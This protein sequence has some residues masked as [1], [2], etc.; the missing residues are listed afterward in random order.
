MQIS[1]DRL[2]L[3][4]PDHAP[5]DFEVTATS[6]SMARRYVGQGIAVSVAPGPCSD[7]MSDAVY[8]DRVQVALAQGVLK[9]CGGARRMPGSESRAEP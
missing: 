4:R 7:G 8:A 1:G 6:K 3:E 2:L 5:A 9:G